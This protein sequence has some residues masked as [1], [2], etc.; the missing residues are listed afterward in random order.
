MWRGDRWH[1]PHPYPH[2]STITGT[3]QA[4]ASQFTASLF[5]PAH[6]ADLFA[7]SGAKYVVVTAKHHEGFTLYPSKVRSSGSRIHICRFARN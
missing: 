7:A 3:Y 6:W 1:E 2:T 5:D 4:F